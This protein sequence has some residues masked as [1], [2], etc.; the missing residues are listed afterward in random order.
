[1]TTGS[2]LAIVH[3]ANIPPYVR[4]VRVA[5]AYKNVEYTNTKQSPF[6]ASE[7]FKKKSPL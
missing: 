1:M 7:E 3:G 6:G 4:K 5:L 2:P